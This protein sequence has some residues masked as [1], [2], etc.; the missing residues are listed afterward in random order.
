MGSSPIK[1]D[2]LHRRILAAFPRIDPPL[3]ENI[4]SHP[5]EECY[6]VKDDFRGVRWWTANEELIDENFD[7]LPLFTAKAYQYYLPAFLLRALD[8]FDPDNL[9]L[10]FCVYNLS[11]AETPDDPWYRARLDQFTPEQVS[12]ISSFLECVREDERFSNHYA[13]VER[14]L[15]FWNVSQDETSV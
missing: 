8:T 5:C 9:V 13:H 2:E 12:V 10:Q 15:K 11:Y 7:K 6:G 14:G 1:I 4:T 3:A